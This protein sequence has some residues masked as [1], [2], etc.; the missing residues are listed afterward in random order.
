MDQ[1]AEVAIFKSLWG[2]TPEGKWTITDVHGVDLFPNPGC[3]PDYFTI[4]NRMEMMSRNPKGR[5][6]DELVQAMGS[7]NLVLKQSIVPVVALVPGAS[8][9]RVIGTAFVVSA[10][11]LV[12][13][14][15]HV[16]MDPE[17]SGYG[18]VTNDNGA[19]R[20]GEGLQMGVLFPLHPANHCPGAVRFAPFELCA[21][22]GGWKVSPLFHER[23][24]MELDTDVAVCRLPP[25]PSGA[26]QP[27]NLSLRP[28]EISEKVFAVGYAEMENIPVRYEDGRVILNPFRQDLY[29][30][31]GTT[32][33]VHHDNKVTR[34][35][36]T[37]GP[38]F[39]FDAKIPGKMSGSPILGGDGAVIRGVVSKSFSGERSA[40]GALLGPATHLP[41]FD[42]RSI[43]D[44][45]FDGTDGIPRIQ[46]A[47][48]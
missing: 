33:A 29:V 20:F 10:S 39:E 40:S 30:S 14:A 31:V 46:G 2:R 43:K 8:A 22:W 27:L 9:L 35:A 48:L 3:D 6:M 15:G 17:D 7:T 18:N 13:T 37:P 23:D 28:V 5:T 45:M 47:G 42:H 34:K 16:L 1:S 38:C 25:H 11:G 44:M 32:T 21:Y 4:A 19:I 36:T 12:M 41:V 26:Y 24:R